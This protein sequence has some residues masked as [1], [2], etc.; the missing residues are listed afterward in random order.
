MSWDAK[1]IGR[2]NWCKSATAPH[3]LLMGRHFTGT[4]NVP[5]IDENSRSHQNHKSSV[6][7]KCNSSSLPWLPKKK[8]FFHFK[9]WK[10]R[11]PVLT[12]LIESFVSSLKFHWERED[13]YTK[14]ECKQRYSAPSHTSICVQTF[15]D[16]D[17]FICGM[18]TNHL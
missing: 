15:N 6:C 17:P 7:Q 5:R 3:I 1:A 2:I 10:S 13:N 9:K 8:Q 18:L 16:N 14:K 12:M 11:T 4:I